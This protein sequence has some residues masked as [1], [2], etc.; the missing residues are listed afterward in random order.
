M[1]RTKKRQPN[2]NSARV[3]RE[4]RDRRRLMFLFAV[5]TL[6]DLKRIG[7]VEQHATETPTVWKLARAIDATLHRCQ[8]AHARLMGGIPP[9]SEQLTM[10][11]IENLDEEQV[12][13]WKSLTRILISG[14]ASP[15]KRS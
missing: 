6:D 2:P 13:K 9:R 3:R 4:S 14:A 8:R 11:E 10:D 5:L 1:K 12:A 7:L 15:T